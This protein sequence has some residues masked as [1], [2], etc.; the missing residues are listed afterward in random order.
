MTT[1]ST[2]EYMKQYYQDN[3]ENIIK[4]LKPFPVNIKAYHIDHIIP[5]ASFDFSIDSEIKK[6]FAPKNHQWLLAEENLKKGK[7]I[8]VQSVLNF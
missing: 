8:Q 5:L 7:R 6:A 1:I 4:H 3:K 2:S